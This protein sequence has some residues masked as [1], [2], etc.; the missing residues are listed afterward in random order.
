MS[1]PGFTQLLILDIIHN[2][3]KLMILQN[4]ALL[5]TFTVEFIILIIINTFVLMLYNIIFYYMADNF[6]FINRDI[7]R[8]VRHAFQTIRKIQRIMESTE[9]QRRETNYT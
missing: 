9:K 7:R 4:T 1:P 6:F 5:L 3:N 8:Y 2:V